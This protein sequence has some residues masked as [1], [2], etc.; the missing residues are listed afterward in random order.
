M[1]SEPQLCWAAGA[2]YFCTL[3]YCCLNTR[4]FESTRRTKLGVGGNLFYLVPVRQLEGAGAQ[5][6]LMSLF[7]VKTVYNYGHGGRFGEEA[8]LGYGKTWEV[9]GGLAFT[10]EF[11]LSGVVP[12]GERWMWRGGGELRNRARESGAVHF[13]RWEETRR[14]EDVREKGEE[15]TKYK[16]EEI[17]VDIDQKYYKRE[18]EE[19]W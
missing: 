17:W 18:K 19:E 11:S 14:E 7:G 9:E 10:F 13:Q 16:E 8:L 6:L 5:H 4:G 2:L 15:F 3:N 1:E 12:G